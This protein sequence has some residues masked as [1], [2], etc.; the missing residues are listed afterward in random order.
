MGR[1]W[2]RLRRRMAVDSGFFGLCRFVSLISCLSIPSIMLRQDAADTLSPEQLAQ[3]DETI[4]TLKS[5]ITTLKTTQRNLTTK[6]NALLSAPTTASLHTLISTLT[7]TNRLKVEKLRG[8]KEGGVKMVSKEEVMNV[9]REVKEWTTK[10]KRRM[11]AFKGL[12][13]ICLQGP[14]KKDELWEKAGL[15]EDCYMPPKSL[16]AASPWI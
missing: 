10:R 11:D 4:S 15:E 3:M 14:W 6:L 16:S 9:D 5:T 8:F 1:L 13:E 2:G 12:E 7:E